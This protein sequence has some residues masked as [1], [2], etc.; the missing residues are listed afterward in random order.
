MKFGMRFE[1]GAELALALDGLP[2]RVTK[3]LVLEALTEG[4][5]PMR[6]FARQ[7]APREPGAPDMADHIEIANAK[8]PPGDIAAVAMGPTRD[9]YYGLMQEY[10]TVHHGAQPFMRP[11]FGQGVPPALGII[12]AA[13]WRELAGRGITRS[14]TASSGLSGADAFL[15]GRTG[16]RSVR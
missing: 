10:G 8:T 12:G 15:G 9:F 16:L 5:G 11:A 3:K 1:G 6:G 14:A 4:A 13:V 2:K 7:R